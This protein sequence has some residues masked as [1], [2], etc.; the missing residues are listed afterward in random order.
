MEILMKKGIILAALLTVVSCASILETNL[1][2]AAAPIHQWECSACTFLNQ[3]HVRR[4]E[5]CRESNPDAPA[6][7][8]A[9]PRVPSK[10][11]SRRVS[12]AHAQ[13]QYQAQNIREFEVV[14]E[15]K[16]DN[17]C[18]GLLKTDETEIYVLL[19]STFDFNSRNVRVVRT[20]SHWWSYFQ[21]TKVGTVYSIKIDRFYEQHAKYIDPET[22]VELPFG[23]FHQKNKI[24][25]CLQ[26]QH[27][28]TIATTLEVRQASLMVASER[29]SMTRFASRP[30]Q[31]IWYCNICGCES[32]I[33]GQHNQCRNCGANQGAQPDQKYI[34]EQEEASGKKDTLSGMD[35]KVI[36]TK[37]AGKIFGQDEKENVT[38]MICQVE[39]IFAETCSGA[40][41]CTG[42]SRP[43]A[44]SSCSPQ[45]IAKTNQCPQCKS[46]TPF[47]VISG[48]EIPAVS[49]PPMPCFL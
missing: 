28:P 5:M 11:A 40:L 38:C 6:P 49:T 30:M 16:D 44:C 18:F 24:I 3:S 47:W 10:P 43:I 8:Q 19:D 21:Q 36:T 41:W 31:Q 48:V 34:L 12:W 29:E 45:T 13:Q 9:S 14:L 42:C 25:L 37:E 1:S 33:E 15:L 32:N 7:A 23:Q 46:Q 2:A 4:C 39:E 20:P 26:G 35:R 17:G 22:Q 27:P